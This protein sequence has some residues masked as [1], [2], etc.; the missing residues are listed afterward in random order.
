MA[1]YNGQSN[2]QQSNEQPYAPQ[3]IDKSGDMVA[4]TVATAQQSAIDQKARLQDYINSLTQLRTFAQMAAQGMAARGANGMQNPMQVYQQV[5]QMAAQAGIPITAEIG[6][7]LQAG[8][9]IENTLTSIL[10]S[11]SKVYAGLGAIPTRSTGG[12]QVIGGQN[13]R[14]SQGNGNGGVRN[15]NADSQGI[16]RLG[17]L[18]NER[19]AQGNLINGTGIA[20][21]ATPDNSS[22]YPNQNYNPSQNSAIGNIPGQQQ[23]TQPQVADNSGYQPYTLD[24]L[25]LPGFFGEGGGDPNHP[26]WSMF[27]ASAYNQNNRNNDDQQNSSDA[28]ANTQGPSGVDAFTGYNASSAPVLGGGSMPIYDSSNWS[29]GNFSAANPQGGDT[30]TPSLGG[31]D[32]GASPYNPY[33]GTN[34]ATA[35]VGYDNPNENFNNGS[36][37][38]PENPNFLP[39]MGGDTSGGYNDIPNYNY[40]NFGYGGGEEMYA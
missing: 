32:G 35:D 30:N 14:G 20:R 10:D 5:Q 1:T 37:N 7:A 39:V 18:G 15:P 6:K 33:V 29:S 3:Y 23:P 24:H 9:N 26:M 27:A 31:W 13:G 34:Y 4:N 25:N 22:I 12:G 19:D 36:N 16:Q 28:Q 40:D 21:P 8:N 38:I 11:A 2:M 17:S